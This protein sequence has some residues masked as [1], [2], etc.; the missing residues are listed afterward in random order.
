M[1]RHTCIIYCFFVFSMLSACENTDIPLAT[2]AGLDAVRAVTLSDKA[3]QDIAGRSAIHADQTNKI[4]SP[5]N[6]YA[7]RLTKLVGNQ[8]QEKDMHF[9]LKKNRRALKTINTNCLTISRS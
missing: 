8:L 3:V 1:R 7:R 9:N 5:S 6:P 2:E 4:A